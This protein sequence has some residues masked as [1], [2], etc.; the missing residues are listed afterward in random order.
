MGLTVSPED[1]K[2][3]SDYSQHGENLYPMDFSALKEKVI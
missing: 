1:K 2:I 3:G